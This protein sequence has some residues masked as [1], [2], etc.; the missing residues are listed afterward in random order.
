MVYLTSDEQDIAARIKAID[1]QLD[2]LEAKG[3][4]LALAG[5]RSG[6]SLGAGAAS[7]HEGEVDAQ[8]AE[9]LKAREALATELKRQVGD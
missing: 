2:E 8:H 5:L 3:R 1:R 6:G 4:R 7:R 9:L